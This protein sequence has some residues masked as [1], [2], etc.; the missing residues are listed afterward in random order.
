MA[1]CQ[2]AVCVAAIAPLTPLKQ[3]G[4]GDLQMEQIGSIR[5]RTKW[6]DAGMEAMVIKK[7]S[8]AAHNN[9]DTLGGKCRI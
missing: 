4:S 2:A 9:C 5:T 7:I 1:G 6:N 3:N 8:V